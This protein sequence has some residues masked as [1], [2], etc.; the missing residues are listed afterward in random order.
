[1]KMTR[2]LGFGLVACLTNLTVASCRDDQGA[3]PAARAVAS[4]A[5]RNVAAPLDAGVSGP[6]A[7]CRGDRDCQFTE[8][9]CLSGLLGVCSR[10]EAGRECPVADLTLALPAD[11][12][13][14]FE[15]LL[16]DETNCL[17]QKC[18]SGPGARRLLRFSVDVVNRGD[19]PMILALPDAPGVRRIACDGSTS[20]FLEGFLRYEL[21][22]AEG[23]LRA[24][25]VGDIGQACR[26]NFLAAATSPFDCE[27]LG[28]EAHSYR[29]FPSDA[30]C[31]WVDVTTLAPGQYT[32][33]LSVNADYRLKEES[34]TN[35]VV[36]RTVTIPDADPL[37]PCDGVDVPDDDSLI[38]NMECGW[39]MMPGQSGLLCEPGQYITLACTYCDGAYVARA[40]PGLEP[41]SAAGSQ[42][43]VGTGGEFDV[44]SPEDTCD[45]S[46]GCWD[47]EF[48]CPATGVFSLLGFPTRPSVPAGTAPVSAPSRVT[49]RL[50]LGP[51]PYELAPLRRAAGTPDTERGVAPDAGTPD[52]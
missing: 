45:E 11:F 52:P 17:R 16:I 30:E 38:Q 15:H 13:P 2:W 19:A 5:E 27:L 9:C 23:V 36:E 40:C 3:P 6:S 50:A 12:K 46:G 37:A 31:Q 33:R 22:D 29:A 32:L 43:I 49:C 28:L 7:F 21:F 44:C 24:S 41:C 1:M 25:G 26:M 34:L 39:E 35:N 20:L 18:L 14:R 10:L 51:R 48:Q 47:F 4:G 8:R 42:R